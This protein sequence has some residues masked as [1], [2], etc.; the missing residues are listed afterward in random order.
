MQPHKFRASSLAEIMA[1]PVSIDRALLSPELLVVANKKTKTDADKEAL[2]PYWDKSLSAGAKTAIEKLAKQFIYGYNEVISGKYMDKGIQ[3]EDQS[4][5]LINSVFFTNYKKNTERKSNDW[6]TGECDIFIPRQKIIDV[7]SS[8]SLATFPVTSRAGEDKTY[9]WQGRAYMW[10]WD[11][12]EFE[13]N[14]ALVNTP[15]ELIGYEDEKL[16]YVDHIAEELRVTRVT[17]KR[18]KS[19]EDKI[20]TKVEAAHVYMQKM[21]DQIIAEH[22]H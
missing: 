12:D 14:Y 20:K 21:V 15:D 17:Y 16:H 5:D 10:L 18:E 13:I 19:L 1:D 22:T 2:A 4:I 8:W 11:V 7:K 9:E 6:I 3:V